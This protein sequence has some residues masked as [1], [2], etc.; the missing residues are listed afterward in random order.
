MSNSSVTPSTIA[1]QAPSVHGISQ[2]RILEWAVFPSPGNFPYTGIEPAS[3][4]LAGVIFTS[5]PPGKPIEY[6]T[7][8]KKNI[9]TP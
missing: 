7:A 6:D 4:A 2:A 1:H 3:P 9:L 5:E 8:T